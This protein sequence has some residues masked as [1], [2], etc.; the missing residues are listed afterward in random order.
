MIEALDGLYTP[1][2]TSCTPSQ[3]LLVD[4]PCLAAALLAAAL[5]KIFAVAGG[6]R[7]LKNSVSSLQFL[8]NN[9]D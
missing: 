2:Y 9:N 3:L 6:T 1:M 5:L 7:T 8:G 4:P